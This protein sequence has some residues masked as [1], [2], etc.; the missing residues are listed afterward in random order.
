MFVY[1]SLYLF[2]SAARWSLSEDSYSSLI[3]GIN[4]DSEKDMLI[5]LLIASVKSSCYETLGII[6]GVG[7]A[8]T[9]SQIMR[10]LHKVK[11]IGVIACT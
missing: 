6:R 9:L 1:G 7:D 8:M 10:R 3:F 11:E 4:V 2:W 5:C